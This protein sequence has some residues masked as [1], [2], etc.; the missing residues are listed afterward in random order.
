MNFPLFYCNGCSY[1]DENYRP[2][3]KENVYIDRV[4]EYVGAG[5]VLNKAIV[6]SNNRRIIRT[7][8]H[9]LI[10]Q[11]QLNPSQK[12]IALIQLTFEL[13][14]ELW[15][16]EAKKRDC[17]TPEE[18]EFIT[19]QFSGEIDWRARLLNF[20][21]IKS[22]NTF[23]KNDTAQKFLDDYSKGRAFFYSPYQ[24]RINLVSD[25]LM[26]TNI[27][28]KLNIEF[29]IFQ[30]PIAEKLESE[31]LLD[32]FKSLLPNNILNLETFGFC[33]WCAN[34]NFT[35]IDKNE[36][37]F[38]GHYGPDAHRAFA[39]NIIIPELSKLKII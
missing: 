35:P 5:F 9:D 18:S 33:D 4:R 29:L 32:F 23:V 31:Y 8:L 21:S 20:I 16:P 12:I 13:R 11:R 26:F 24:E 25:L 22:H 39:D 27:L 15:Y 19:H 2:E 38:I 14:E 36:I 1:S 6:G 30:G 7:S 28:E 10:Q 34:Q 37:P 3:M 17:W